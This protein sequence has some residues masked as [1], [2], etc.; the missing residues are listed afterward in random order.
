[1]LSLRDKNNNLY[2][3][4]ILIENVVLPLALENPRCLSV[5]E[6]I[7]IIRLFNRVL[8]TGTKS[9]NDTPGEFR[10]NQVTIRNSDHTPPD[11][12]NVKDHVVAF[13]DDV[14]RIWD[15][16]PVKLYAFVLWKLN[17]IHP[18]L[19]GNGRTSRAFSY[20]LLCLKFG[21]MIP[22]IP[23]ITDQFQQNKNI[24]YSDLREADKG[25]LEPL[26]AHSRMY[27]KLQLENAC[28]SGILPAVSTHDK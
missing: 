26:E 7:E 13:A 17:W 25:N 18:F 15:G 14:K 3:L 20:F 24:Y 28:S 6:I 5:S 27:L 23:S 4:D 21:K 11:A 8:T 16:D 19:D 22:G 9:E 1:M 2:N 12:A 10:L